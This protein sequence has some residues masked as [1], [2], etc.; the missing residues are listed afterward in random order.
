[1]LL[2]NVFVNHQILFLNY[3]ANQ[4]EDKFVEF[5]DVL[6]TKYHHK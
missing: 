3:D 1:M 6:D 5:V 2:N 4:H